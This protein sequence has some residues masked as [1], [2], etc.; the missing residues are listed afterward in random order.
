M[1]AKVLLIYSLISGAILTLLWVVFRVAGLNRL[2]CHRLNRGILIAILLL[3]VSLPFVAF[4]DR[5]VA[6]APVGIPA[7]DEAAVAPVLEIGYFDPQP[8]DAPSVR[9][10]DKA[11]AVLPVIYIAGLSVSALWLLF[12]LAGIALSIIKGEKRRIDSHTTLVVHSRKMTPFTWG[13]WIIIS[14]DDLESNA[15]MLLAHE[16]AHKVAVHWVDLLVCRMVA[17][18]DW[19]WLPAWFL[20]RDIAAVHEY[21]AD[22]LVLNGGTDAVAYQMLLIHKAAPG[23]FTNI[24]NPFNYSSLKNRIAMMQKKQ[25]SAR[26]RMRCLVML[27]AAALAIYFSSAS[28]LAATVHS[29]LP[30]ES[31]NATVAVNNVKAVAEAPVVVAALP[32]V[33]P[34]NAQ[35]SEPAAEASESVASVI[36]LT[37]SDESAKRHLY[38]VDG[39]VTDLTDLT[40]LDNN[41]VRRINIDNSSDAVEK[42][43][44]AG[45]NGV[46]EV[47]TV[48]APEAFAAEFEKKFENSTVLTS[49]N[50]VRVVKRN[51]PGADQAEPVKVSPSYKGGDEKMYMFLAKNIRYPEEAVKNNI[52][53]KIMVQFL[54]KADGTIDDVKAL[55]ENNDPNLEAEAIRVIKLMPA[56]NPG[57]IDGKPADMLHSLPIS[58]KLQN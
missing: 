27:P 50:A 23:F 6:V 48:N 25:S 44:E 22:R 32:E 16:S 54:V 5:P 43:G 2:T 11:T 19:Y 53:G 26:S 7:A 1:I 42:Y 28:A 38:V 18:I 8:V 58:F 13:R 51:V 31:D 20:S 33:S 55:G 3:S 17:C 34:E 9:L 57:T 15:E 56:F 30:E 10:I 36:E 12:A 45:R 46:V 52:Q 35:P 41:K 49:E 29:V 40:S 47:L 14:R 21:Q 39:V 4:I 37:M 24:A